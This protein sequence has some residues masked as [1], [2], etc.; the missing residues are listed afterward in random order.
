MDRDVDV[1]RL[2]RSRRVGPQTYH[3]LVA[4]HGSA[5]AALEALP[6]LAKSAGVS[7]YTTCSERE[8]MAELAAGRRAG[9]V[10]LRHDSPDYPAALG[11]LADAPPV[12]WVRGQVGLLARQGVALVG[13]R[14]ASSLGL[15]MA[16]ILATGLSQ[17]GQVVVSGLARGIDAEAHRAALPATVAVM[18]G[19]ID[20]IYP[21][22]N[23]RLAAKIAEMG[24]LV[25]E[26]PPA[27]VP[28]VRH[29]PLRNRI[30]AGLSQ[31][32][33]VIEGAIKSGSLITARIAAEQ[34]REVMAVPG[35]PLDAR[36]SGTNALIRDGAVMVRQVEDIVEV[37]AHRGP[38][39]DLLAP[40][41]WSSDPAPPSP[42]PLHPAPDRG[43]N[44][45]DAQDLARDVI[46]L[47][48]P[49][50]VLEDDLIRDLGIT[51]GDLAPV[52]LD[53]ELEGRLLRLAGGRIALAA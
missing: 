13:S 52:L 6:A 4:E 45:R 2:I 15:R 33:V 41:M 3:R 49:S 11:M 21:A 46:D 10:L 28:Q 1:I 14:N 16:R 38:P 19:G 26:Q 40:D 5:R 23:A 50:P 29:F 44:P 25:T 18:A 37:L 51:A 27:T 24:A 8:A 53:L 22:E 47:L 36:A 48:G 31:A 9:A 32:V 39:H 35:H 30:V 42:P 7:D 43:A 34:G 17:R 20:V 12:L